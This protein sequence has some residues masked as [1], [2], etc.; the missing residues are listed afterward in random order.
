MIGFKSID[1]YVVDII[2]FRYDQ[3][4][5]QVSMDIKNASTYGMSE[6]KV[7]GV[8]SKVTDQDL[9][10]DISIY[11]PHITLE[12]DYQGEGKFNDFHVNSGGYVNVTMSKYSFSILLQGIW[13]LMKIF[14][15]LV[16]VKGVWKLRGSVESPHHGKTY[17]KIKSFNV[18]PKIK[19]M[20]F[21]AT[22]LF[23]DPDLTQL[24]VEFLNQNWRFLLEQ[25]FPITKR[26][27]EPI[28]LEVANRIFDQIPYDDLLPK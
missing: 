1:P 12:S 24:A 17:M 27:W 7:R 3:G 10:L 14:C 18:V 5:I 13:N 2:N 23:P 22:G 19:S 28:V 20:K 21:Y 16:D 25:F 6:T 15:F 4:A 9:N 26:A 8:K 11:H